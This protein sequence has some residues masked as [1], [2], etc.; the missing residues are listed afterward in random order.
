M[1]DIFL[2]RIDFLEEYQYCLT[3]SIFYIFPQS[4]REAIVPAELFGRIC[5][6]DYF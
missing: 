6:K 3:H 5:E 1:V 4:S 2:I